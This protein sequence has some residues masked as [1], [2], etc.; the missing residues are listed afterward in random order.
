MS[1]RSVFAFVYLAGQ[2][3]CVKP[4]ASKA[5]LRNPPLS[6]APWV[7]AKQRPTLHSFLSSRY[8]FLE[9]KMRPFLVSRLFVLLSAFVSTGSALEALADS[10]CAVQ[11]G[12][13]LGG[14]SG[15]D[16][17]CPDSS[18]TSTLAGQTFSTCI[19]CQLA[20]KY[21]D[22]VTKT[23]DLQWGLCEFPP[24]RPVGAAPHGLQNDPNG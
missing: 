2:D 11:C 6:T 12:N 9:T 7:T 18:Y 4:L 10:P 1:C 21:Q 5:Q 14:T 20:S 24:I 17:V 16:I 19:T 13:V 15:N 8:R 3:P 23:T 22:P